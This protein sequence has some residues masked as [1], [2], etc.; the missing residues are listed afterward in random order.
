LE[1]KSMLCGPLSENLVNILKSLRFKYTIMVRLYNHNGI[2]WIK[3]KRIHMKNKFFVTFVLFLVILI[4]TTTGVIFYRIRSTLKDTRH[5]TGIIVP[6]QIPEYHFAMICKD[7]DAPA[8]LSIKKGVERASKEFNVA[9][10]FNTVSTSNEEDLYKYL[11]I[12]IASKVDG[13]VTYVWDDGQT[14]LLIDRAMEEGI[15]VVTIGT[16]AKESKRIAYVGENKYTSGVQLGR[17]IIAVTEKKGEVVLLDSNKKGNEVMAQNLMI[18]GIRDIIKDYPDIH[19][20]T[21]EYDSS[22][23]LGIEDAVSTLIKDN[24]ELSTLVCTSEK[25]TLAVADILVDL[26]K[27]GYNIIGYGNSSELLR[28]IERGVV[29]GTVNVDHEQMGYDTIRALVDVRQN[30]RTSAYFK[31]DSFTITKQNVSKYIK[32]GEE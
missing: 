26:N 14:G 2:I 8:W 31:V 27:V 11:D 4:L 5:N 22:N 9:V 10:E 28:Y 7:D 29:F 15:P 23:F 32:S 19:M 6:D 20:T 1:I 21:V 17:M 16:D 18:M 3:V 25:D 24:P 13:I 30:D 12:A